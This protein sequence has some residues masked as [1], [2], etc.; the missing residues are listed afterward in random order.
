MKEKLCK[1]CAYCS[2]NIGNIFERIFDR[3]LDFPVCHHPSTKSKTTGKTGDLCHYMR[4]DISDCGTEGKLF[5][6]K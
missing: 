5:K 4:C 1:D 3:L 6:K 2:L